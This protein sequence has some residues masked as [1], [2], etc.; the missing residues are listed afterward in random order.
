MMRNKS[1]CAFILTHGRA[2]RVY[3]Y[4]LLKRNRFTGKIIL[5][6]DDE[7]DQLIEYRKRY[8]NQVVVF[9][10]DESAKTFDKMDNFTDRRSG[11]YAR[12]V[13]FD[14]ANKFGYKYFIE[15]DDDYTY[16]HF[17]F[18]HQGRYTSNSIINLDRVFDAMVDFYRKTGALSV[19][20]AQ[21]G[22]FMGGRESPNISN[23]IR[24]IRKVMNTF[25]CG[26]DRPFK[27]TGKMN[28]DVNTYTS[29]GSLGH[30]FLTVMQV[31]I[32]QQATQQNPGGMSEYYLNFGTYVKSFYPVMLC[33]SS[34]RISLMGRTDR[35]FHHKILWNKTVPMILS[36]KLRKVENGK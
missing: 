19:A 18:D 20:M 5:I 14:L 2:D 12:N 36:E 33:P 27:F 28:D 7:D 15:L 26:T 30:L 10:K 13:C 6:I 34:V 8:G 4:D 9:N 23:G 3:T 29:L 16:V 21:G 11:V 17:R 24:M 1:F 35:R 32:E 25:I 22:D 31:C